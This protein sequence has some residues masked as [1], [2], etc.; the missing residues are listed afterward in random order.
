MKGDRKKKVTWFKKGHVWHEPRTKPVLNC[1]DNDVQ[2]VSYARLSREKYEQVIN[3]PLLNQ[4]NMFSNTMLLRPKT[5][6]LSDAAK[7]A[8]AVNE[9]YLHVFFFTIWVF[10]IFLELTSTQ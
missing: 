2:T 3:G 9:R 8:T 10:C 5:C 6:E 4:G 7:C 1:L